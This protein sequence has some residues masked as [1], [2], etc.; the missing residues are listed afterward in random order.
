MVVVLWLVGTLYAGVAAFLACKVFEDT[1][2]SNSEQSVEYHGINFQNEESLREFLRDSQDSR[3]FPWIYAL[4]P[5]LSPVIAAVAFGVLGGVARILRVITF[6]RSPISA[7]PVIVMPAFSG[8]VGLMLFFLSFLMPAVFTAG[9][10]PARPET[11]VGLS[12]FGGLFSER[13]YSWISSQVAKVFDRNKS[14]VPETQEGV[15]VKRQ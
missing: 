6:D 1:S 10:N 14:G 7:L 12:F 8:L 3:L 5:E 9:R 15:T 11:L 13:A 4:P 2:S